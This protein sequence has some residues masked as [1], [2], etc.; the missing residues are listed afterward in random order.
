MYS[1]YKIIFESLDLTEILQ[2]L[3][4]IIDMDNLDDMKVRFHLL[5]DRYDLRSYTD[6]LKGLWNISHQHKMLLEECKERKEILGYFNIDFK[7]NNDELT[8][9]QQ[10]IYD[11][12]WLFIMCEDEFNKKYLKEDRAY[13]ME[14]LNRLNG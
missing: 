14:K 5:L 9:S 8:L 7:F 10:Y 13:K 1:K 12:Y 6:R 11:Y 4:R 3:Q 2:V